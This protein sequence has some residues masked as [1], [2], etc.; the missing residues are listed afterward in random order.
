VLKLFDSLSIGKGRTKKFSHVGSQSKMSFGIKYAR[1]FPKWMISLLFICFLSVSSV[2]SF[3]A[4]LPNTELN[5]DD[6]GF[7]KASSVMDHLV[8]GN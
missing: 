8:R 4:V 3:A 6:E 1:Y 2:G 7:F 5:E